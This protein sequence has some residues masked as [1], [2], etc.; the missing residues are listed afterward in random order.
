MTIWY[1]VKDPSA[2]L[3]YEGDWTPFLS[4]GDTIVT[5]TWTPLRADG[6]PDTGITVTTTLFAPTN[7]IVW[8]TGGHTDD[9]MQVF[10][11]MHAIVNHITTNQGR[12]DDQTLYLD[13]FQ[14]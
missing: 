9:P 1:A 8:L 6:S 2:V 4:P 10:G 13:I 11:A 5:S 3:D 12:Q 14:K 7:T